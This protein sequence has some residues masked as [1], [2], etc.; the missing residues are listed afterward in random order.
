EIDFVNLEKMPSV[1]DD[2]VGNPLYALGQEQGAA[3]VLPLRGAWSE[4]QKCE[5]HRAKDSR[6][7][8]RRLSEAGDV[9]FL[10]AGENAE[11]STLLRAMIALKTARYLERDG[12]DGFERPGYRSYFPLMTHLHHADGAVHLSALEVGGEILAAHW[13]I[14]HNGAFYCLMLGY[15]T[16][17]LGQY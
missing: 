10:I 15:I 12:A 6:R 2:R 14:I 5:L 1:I 13:G 8:R 4:Y 9:R 16:A 17:G 3:H 7:K 11:A